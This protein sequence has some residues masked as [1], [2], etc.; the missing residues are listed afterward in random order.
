MAVLSAQRTCI[1]LCR[2]SSNLTL[3][4]LHEIAESA[5]KDQLSQLGFDVSG[6]VRCSLHYQNI[7]KT[8]QADL[9]P[10]DRRSKLYFRTT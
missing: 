7:L 4:K 10:H 6:N 8:I 5:M 9:G 3:N 1:S 2:K